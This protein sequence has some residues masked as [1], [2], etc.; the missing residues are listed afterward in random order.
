M[1]SLRTYRLC[2][3]H[4]DRLDELASLVLILW[5]LCAPFVI[6][7]ALLSVY[8]DQHIHGVSNGVS[9]IQTVVPLLLFLGW[10]LV[11]GVLVVFR[12]RTRYQEAQLWRRMAFAG[13]LP[14]FRL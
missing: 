14:L 8:D 1:L 4:L 11:V 12:I 7:Q 6:F 3:G 5:C 2:R 9:S 13:A 10:M